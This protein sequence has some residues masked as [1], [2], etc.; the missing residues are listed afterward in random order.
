[1]LLINNN[2]F[3]I[4]VVLNKLFSIETADVILMSVST[5]SHTFPPFIK[6]IKD[7]D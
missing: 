4:D 7:Q 3:V 5:A 6:Q 2:L 1:M